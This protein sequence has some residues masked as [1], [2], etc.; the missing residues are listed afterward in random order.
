MFDS[1]WRRRTPSPAQ[2]QLRVAVLAGF[3]LVLFTV[4]FFRLWYLEV[5][6]GDRYLAQA[7]NNQVRE[8]T[9]QAPRGVITDRDGEE[10][11][12]N[13]T[14]LEL[15]VK[16]DELPEKV[17][18]RRRLFDRLSEL[19]RKS[20]AEV[21][22]TIREQ[23]KELPSSPATVQRDVPYETVYF[24]RENQEHFPGVS[25]ERVYVRQ[26]PQGDLAAHLLGYVREVDQEE[27]DDPRF[28]TLEPGD[29]VGKAGVEDAYDSLLRGVNGETRVQVDASGSPSG[30]TLTEREP[31]QG[32]DLVLSL[33]SDVQRAGQS[34]IG[35]FGLPGGFVAMNIKSGELLGVGSYPSYDPSLLG[36]PTV[37]TWVAQQIFGDP[38]DPLSTTA[39]P[40]FNRATQGA[41]LTGSTFKPVTALGALDSGA[42]TLSRVI[43]DG[44]SVTYGDQEFKNAGDV[45]HGPVDLR[46]AL[47]VSS[48]VF[49][50]ILGA[51]TDV[52]EG[53]GGAIQEWARRLGFGEATGIDVGTESV[54][55]IP[56]PDYRNEHYEENTAPDSPCGE[57]V[58]IEK[59]EIT[60]RPW[61]IGDNV[62]LAVG[63]GDLQANPLQMAV[64]Y[65]AIANGGDIVRPHI[66]L[67]VED[68]AGRVVQEIE[69][70]PR[71]HVDI[72]PSWRQTIM[73]GL[74]DAAMSPGGTSYPVFG[75]YPVDIAGKTGTA[76][77]PPNGDQSWYV[78][79]APYDDPKYVVA[80]TV[81]EG[82]F[83]ADTAAPAAQQILN[84]LLK[85]N[86]AKIHQV[87]GEA[88]TLE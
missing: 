50:Y 31:R 61:S 44:G 48:D 59:G 3:A 7:E 22:K 13:R 26:Y 88:A 81:E 77:R 68:P 70:A 47:Q 87:S 6:S 65:G 16:A 57:E 83:G 75:G 62:N 80:V 49:F 72:D 23:T 66:G 78:A 35:S 42:L 39:A 85:V 1:E 41:Y 5:L 82:G 27:L 19:T 53:D 34:A 21:R 69:P 71:R 28:E 51:E 79:V 76:E 73:E 67:R 14:A 29:Y 20:P 64:A 18:Q 43:N 45:A 63:Q 37:P 24:L 74:H 56:T 25:V 84:E 40:A 12:T 55:R 33:D 60:D 38:N 46:Q 4:V 17:A 32:N 30:R 15:Q 9:V 2:L 52:D 11:V 54:G 86:E 8:F 58:C 36:R 10:L